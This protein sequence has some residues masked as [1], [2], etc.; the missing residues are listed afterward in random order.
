ME[1]QPKNERRICFSGSCQPEYFSSAVYDLQI[2][3]NKSIYGA[4]LGI[5]LLKAHF[6]SYGIP[7]HLFF[8]QV[9]NKPD[10]TTCPKAGLRHA[11]HISLPVIIIA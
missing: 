6:L 11:D 9:A 5:K 8:L 1:Q 3:K 10:G 4:N 7:C 2:E